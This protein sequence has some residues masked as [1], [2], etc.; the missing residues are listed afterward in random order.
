MTGASGVYTTDVTNGTYGIFINT[1][2]TGVSL[3]IDDDDG[4]AALDYFTL[5]LNKGTGISDVL[6]NSGS[7]TTDVFLSGT[8]V[9]IDASVMA[10]YTWVNWTVTGSSTEF[11]DDQE[12]TFNID[13]TVNITANA[14][15]TTYTATVTVTLDDEGW[16][17]RT[18]TLHDTMSARMYT[19][20][21]TADG[22]Y[23][24][25]VL[26]GTYDVR[27]NTKDVGD[28]T[29]TDSPNSVTAEFFTLTVS[30]GTGTSSPVGSGIYLAGESV[31][32]RVTVTTGWTFKDWTAVGDI[33][34]VPMS[35][36][37][38]IAMPANKLT[39]TAA[40]TLNSYNVN[41]NVTNTTNDAPLK[42]NHGDQLSFTLTPDTGYDMP[43]TLTITRGGVTFLEGTDYT[44]NRATGVVTIFSGRIIADITITG[45]A[46]PKEPTVTVNVTNTTNNALTRLSY[47]SSL[48][49]TI[50]AIPGYAL[51]SALTVTMGDDTLTEGVDYVWNGAVGTFHIASVTGDVTITGDAVLI[52]YIVT[53]D[54]SKDGSSW[55]GQSMTLNDGAYVLEDADDGKYVS[56][57]KVTPG[58]YTIWLNGESTGVPITIGYDSENEATLNYYTLTLGK[59]TGIGEVY[60]D[61]SAFTGPVTFLS[62]TSVTINA[63][64]L[65]GYTWADWTYSGGVF[66]T[67]CEYTFA[68]TSVMNLTASGT[69]STYTTSVSVTNTTNNAPSSLPHGSQLSFK[70]IPNIGHTLPASLVVR[71]SGA[72]LDSDHYT[73]DSTTGEF[74]ITHPDGVVGNVTVAGAASPMMFTITGK[75]QDDNGAPLQGATVQYRFVNDLFGPLRTS[76]TDPGGMYTIDVP[77]GQIVEI[78]NIDAPGY[79]PQVNSVP[80]SLGLITGDKIDI[81]FTMEPEQSSPI[82]REMIFT[83]AMAAAGILS[84]LFFLLWRRRYVD[85]IKVHSEDV[86]IQGDDKARRKRDYEFK[87]F[88]PTEGRMMRYRVGE[89][90]EWKFIEPDE[91]GWYVLPGEDVIDHI[92]LEWS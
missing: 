13:S 17:D 69:L 84:L 18:V 31:T 57:V 10:E 1:V 65:T 76:V 44:Y 85:V 42:V 59:G 51:P 14:V 81:D 80:K 43:S 33:D 78:V 45:T 89:E 56:T 6:L 37:A 24:S 55:K 41:V 9:T 36:P 68:I 52:E 61:G 19:L 88:G 67:A 8:S 48:T 71:M 47:G 73:W 63:A 4:S 87:A 11:T 38:T 62:G 91:E 66:T 58:T 16:N 60:I 3:I 86:T 83:V 29:I 25:D 22:K 74:E 27:V 23:S 49:F 70:L 30:A 21:F 40:A 92:T 75:I 79:T 15:L 82:P 7:F 28:I 34:P 12:Y 54:L 2:G 50:T 72:V 90:G 46:A 39:L 53:V 26:P 35:N 20:T 5:A 64:M 77:Y 32:V